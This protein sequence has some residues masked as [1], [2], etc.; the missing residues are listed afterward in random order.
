MTEVLLT[1]GTS[2]TVPADCVSATVECIGGGQGGNAT[3]GGNGADYAKVSN[4]ALN[5]GDSIAIQIGAGGAGVSSGTQNAGGDT[6]FGTYVLA[7]GGGSASPDVGDVTYAGGTGDSSGAGG[8]AA[9]AGGAGASASG[10]TPGAG[11]GDLAGGGGAYTQLIA[12]APT[13]SVS[14]TSAR[15]S[16]GAST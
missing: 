5:P 1:S 12:T 11:D 2:W 6:K 13:A 14:D 8:A 7:K 9:G 3:N 16:F 15:I 10:T 4:L